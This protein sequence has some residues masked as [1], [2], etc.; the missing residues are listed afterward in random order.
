MKKA[1]VLVVEEKALIRM[2]SADIVR[3]AGFTAL[4]AA[5]AD[6]AVSILAG[7]RDIR[8]V[9]VD[10]TISGTMDGLSLAHAI[11]NRWPTV[12]LIVTAALNAMEHGQLPE[13]AHFIRKP[14]SFEQVTAALC[15][16][17]SHYRPRIRGVSR[18]YQ[19]W[20]FL[21][22]LAPPK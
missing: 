5:N 2:E 14:Y 6:D 20:Q 15:E 7:R 1:V 19:S 12:H 11:R 17:R 3:D 8:I 21:P 16:L 10:I 9:L 22:E 4:E 18:R 13:N